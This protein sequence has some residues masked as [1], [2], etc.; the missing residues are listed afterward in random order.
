[1]SSGLSL[2][3][4]GS[5][6]LARSRFEEVAR[7]AGDLDDGPLLAMAALAAGDTVAEIGP[8]R[9]LIALLDEAL[10]RPGV[11]PDQLVRL[12]ARR[13]MATYWTPAGPTEAQARSAAAIDAGRALGD[14]PALGAALVARQFTLRSPDTLEERLTVG[15][16]T[17][18]LAGR[19]HDADLEFRAY[20]WLIPDRYQSGDVHGATADVNTAA[21]IAG[22]RRDPLKRWWVLIWRTLLAG[23]AGDW[24]RA[25]VGA[26]QVP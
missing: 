13:A 10:A 18:A 25:E 26:A 8:D 16:E 22:A 9:E 3:Q 1:M 2:L 7:A 24:E 21:G 6:A 20:Q 12:Q 15:A 17:L 23:L 4:A 11:G 5:L 14:G 19:L